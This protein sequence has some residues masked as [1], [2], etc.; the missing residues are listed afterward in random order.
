M[1]TPQSLNFRYF[2]ND[3]KIEL[4]FILKISKDANQDIIQ[5]NIK[6]SID[7]KMINDIQELVY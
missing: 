3:W 5:S 2:Q 7:I 1:I 6:H 4:K